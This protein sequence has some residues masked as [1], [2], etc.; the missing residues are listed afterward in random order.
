[1]QPS[2]FWPSAC[3]LDH[4]R[5]KDLAGQQRAHQIEI[6]DLLEGFDG[7]IEHGF[8]GREGRS[9]HIATGG[10]DQNIDLAPALQYL[11]AR[12]LKLLFVEH[13]G[14]QGH[15]L[16]AS[17]LDLLRHL[18]GQRLATPEHADLGAG[19]AQTASH[20]TAQDACATGNDCDFAFEAEE[21]VQK[22]HYLS[23]CALL[24]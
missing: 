16:A 15:G 19:L 5:A 10:I 17:G 18:F 22:A 12:R 21:V 9:G 11:V 13:I 1:M 14:G 6:E 20:G 7:Q 8:V 3:G 24:I 23:P 2:G 4:S